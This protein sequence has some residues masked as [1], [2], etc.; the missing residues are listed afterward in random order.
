MTTPQKTVVPAQS[1]ESSPAGAQPSAL[2][3][4]P[5]VLPTPTDTT[6]TDT[7]GDFENGQIETTRLAKPMRYRVYL[8]P[9]YDYDVK[10]RY[11]V[12]YLLHG[13]GYTEDQW[14][15]VGAISAANQLI[16]AGEITPFIIV[17]PYD[18]SYLQ[19]ADYQ[20]DEVFVEQLLPIIDATYRTQPDSSHRAIGGLSR[21]GAWAL[22]LGIRHPNLFGSIGGHSPAIF[23][24]D[25]TS[26]QRRLLA[27]PPHQVPR[28]WLDAGD[29]DGDFATIARFEEF[30]TRNNLPHEWHGFIGW[31]DEKYWAAHVETYLRWYALAWQ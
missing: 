31:H 29:K 1:R 12:L 25:E 7:V 14:T 30:L 3:P 27:I 19:P 5:A 13:Q 8:P 15:R 23:F 21:G 4:M 17:M 18:Y 26:L 22:H 16:T 9:C 24:M 28:I 2:P 20:F 10:V 6:C 11:P